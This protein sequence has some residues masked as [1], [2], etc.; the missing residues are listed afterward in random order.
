MSLRSALAS[1]SMLLSLWALAPAAPPASRPWWEQYTPIVSDGNKQPIQSTAA[2]AV[3]G[4][5]YPT[6]WYG[7]WFVDDQKRMNVGARSW[8]QAAEAGMR[9]IIYYDSGE[10][11]DY[12][13]FFDA[14]GKV[15][16]NGWSLPW[17]KGEPV[18]ARWFGLAAFMADVPWA[19]WP[20]AKDYGL[21]RFTFPDGTPA[22]DLYEA[23]AR[24]N[25]A[26]QWK[27]DHFS[28][29]RVTD[30]VAQRS[31]LAQL[32]ARQAAQAEVAG[33]SGW[34]TVRLIDV[35]FANPQLREF[36]CREIAREIAQQ[37]P[38]GVHIDN[39][40]DLNTTYP[41]AQAFGLW[42]QH[43]FRQW[44]KRRLTPAQLA[45]LGVADLDRFEIR[46][47]LRNQP[48]QPVP[49]MSWRWLH[50]GWTQ[51]RLW[52]CYLLSTA[53]AGL[54]FH[55]AV[56]R[57]AK[58]A[59]R[60]AGLDCLLCGN[61]I[62]GFPGQELLRGSCDIAHFEWRA[63]GNIGPFRG[64]GLPPRGRSAYIV[65]LGAAISP[66]G[67]CWPSIYVPKDLAGPGHEHLHQ[68]M[69]FDCLANRGLL[70]FGHAYLDGYSPGTPA[71]AA[72]VNRFVKAIAPRASR[73][74]P[75]ADVGLVYC[76]WS[77]LA[78]VTVARPL[79]ELLFDEYAG[80]ATFLAHRQQAW[81]VVLSTDLTPERLRQ[82]PIVVLPSVAALSDEQV[83]ALTRYVQQGGRLVATGPSATRFGPER[84]LAPRPTGALAGS[85][86]ARVVTATPGRQYWNADYDPA[87]AAEMGRLL[88]FDGFH[89]RLSTTAPATVGL[90][91]SEGAGPAPLWILELTNYDLD[92]ATDRIAPAP[93]TSVSVR[94]PPLLAG[95]SLRIEYLEPDGSQANR[96]QTLPDERI[97]HDNHAG[98]LT[99]RVPGF[100]HAMIVYLAPSDN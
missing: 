43:A 18:T 86:G 63:Q 85:S 93:E 97:E 91:L 13:A 5:G 42:T 87:A 47:H 17:W 73:R 84:L 10:L 57:A 6:G 62:P 30:D 52:N 16:Y 53:E 89:P 96:P 49:K 32:A 66:A 95:R 44:L 59:A 88:Q 71:S 51:D 94:L 46:D 1:F 81:D 77:A 21:P 75:V 60:Q 19:P 67:Y 70:D 58:D 64:T 65:R 82:Y 41:Q 98:L 4:V 61:L 25:V 39:H 90:A 22:N 78:A 83:Q 56:Y 50:P 29:P 92:V 9:R 28:N 24:R 36:R 35:D 26:G 20:T 54:E 23:L 68:V 34:Q 48:L 55:R 37:R 14:Q 38:D 76:P 11:G 80:W 74:R 12:A 45:E 33:K 3:R 31:G 99:L 100:S 2:G 69:A 8:R 15:I 7:F 72:V 27:F 79:T 40:G